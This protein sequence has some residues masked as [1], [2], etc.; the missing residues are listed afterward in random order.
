VL[1]TPPE[2]ADDCRLAFASSVAVGSVGNIYASGGFE[3]CGTTTSAPP[4]VT[5]LTAVGVLDPAYGQGGTWSQPELRDYFVPRDNLLLSP[6]GSIAAFVVR[7]DGR[8]PHLVF[9]SPD[10]QPVGG[11]AIAHALPLPH[12]EEAIYTRPL[13]RQKD[14]RL[15]VV[16]GQFGGGLAKQW[17]M[18]VWPQ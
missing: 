6:S 13:M 11:D 18:R 3:S 10:G 15:I 17:V 7:D 8:L 5:K 2:D 12:T 16:G 1:L 14:G 9:I 4:F